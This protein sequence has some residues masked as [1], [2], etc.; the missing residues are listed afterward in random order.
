MRARG[1]PAVETPDFLLAVLERANDAVVIVD[2]DLRVILFNA[3]AELIW[4]LDRADVLG[5]H[6]SRLGLEDL[7]QQKVATPAS[8]QANG[9]DTIQGRGS[10][11]K[12][13]RKDGRRIR[14]AL[15][16][17]RVEVGGQSRTIAFVRDITAEVELR[18]KS[19]LLTLVADRTNRAVVVTDRNLG[20]VY[21]NAPFAG[22]FGYSL[23]EV[24]GRQAIELLVGAVYRPPDAGKVAMP[25]R[26]GKRRRGG[27]PLLRQERRRESGSRLTSSRF[28]TGAGR[29]SMCSRC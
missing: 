7:Q 28:E 21:A 9:D 15:S 26:R 5:C 27:N 29:S 16:L 18:E 12:I 1:Y 11:I 17:S 24:K 13:Q 19:A 10:E 25:D 22:M 3:A 14:A 6:V 20:I 4:G 2:S 23:E 8:G